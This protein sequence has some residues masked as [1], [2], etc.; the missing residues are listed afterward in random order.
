MGDTLKDTL[1]ALTKRYGYSVVTKGSETEDVRKIPLEIPAFDYVSGGGV[2]INRITELYGD[3]SSLKSYLCYCAIAKFQKYDWA[4]NAPN[5]IQKVIFKTLKKGRGE[6]SDFSLPEIESV[7]VRRGY[8]PV[9]KVKVK[10]CALVDLEGTY[11]KEWGAKLGIDNEALLYVR[12]GSLNQAIDIIDALLSD[13]SISLLVIDSMIAT[14][15]DAE[16]DAS[17]EN[18]QMAVN[19]RFWNKA[20]RKITGAINRNPESDITLMAINGAYSKVGIAYGDPEKVKNGVAFSL[21]KSLSIR[22]SA[23]K[24]I[25]AK[26]EGEEITVGR[27]ITLRNKKNKVGRPFLEATFYFSFVN[28]GAL[29]A[30][31]TDIA[32]QAIELGLK[33]DL[34][35]R[36]GNF[37]TYG[38]VTGNGMETFKNKLNDSGK[39]SALVEQ[40][41]VGFNER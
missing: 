20:T 14:G 37:Y 10:R 23:L 13:D 4:N 9:K 34:I 12:P 36:K 32:Q 11:E 29:K 33:A 27:N 22:T 24:E 26:I 28:D 19:A 39:L 7:Q 2:P 5:V 21:A 35:D 17:M 3:F 25:K 31:Q 1:D 40:L 38:T 6:T 8:K 30:G 18:E 15:C 41:Y 16:T